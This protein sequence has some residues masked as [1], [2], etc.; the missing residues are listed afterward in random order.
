MITVR[1]LVASAVLAAVSFGIWKGLDALL[2]T[3]LVA[4]LVSVGVA[5][6]VG[7]AVYARVVL[8]MRIPEARQIQALVMG[9]LRRRPAG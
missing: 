6:A 2:G 9:R 5:I 8:A 3:S 7:C 1:I 4:Q